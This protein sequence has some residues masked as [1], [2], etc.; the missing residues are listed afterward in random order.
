[1]HWNFSSFLAF[2]FPAN[3]GTLDRAVANTSLWLSAAAYCE[4]NTYL[5]R[6]YLGYSEGFD[7]KYVIEYVERDVQV[8]AS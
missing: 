2:L 4:T 8:S 5:S 3:E 1:M 7:A 6:T